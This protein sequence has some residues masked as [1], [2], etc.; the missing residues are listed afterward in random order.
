[1]GI[2]LLALDYKEETLF[3]VGYAFEQATYKEDW[4]QAKPLVLK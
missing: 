3:Q 2:Q 4:R 1:M